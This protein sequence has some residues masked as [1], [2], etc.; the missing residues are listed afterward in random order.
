MGNL[1]SFITRTGLCSFRCTKAT[2]YQKV[3]VYD[4]FP[5]QER[6]DGL[7]NP[8]QDYTA[9]KQCITVAVENITIS[10]TPKR[11]RYVEIVTEGRVGHS[12]YI[13]DVKAEGLHD[14]QDV[15]AFFPPGSIN[16][17]DDLLYGM[18]YGTT[19][20]RVQSA[21]FPCSGWSIVGTYTDDLLPS[22]A[23]PTRVRPWPVYNTIIGDTWTAAM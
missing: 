22:Y 17:R 6:P 9:Y 5:P 14:L 7:F 12:G 13:Q 10:W 4:P 8:G 3:Y 23:E 1:Q 15:Q 16:F 18:A 21:D 20:V 2:V 11:G 19:T